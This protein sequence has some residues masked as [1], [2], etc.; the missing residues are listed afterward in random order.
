MVVFSGKKFNHILSEGEIP[1]TLYS[2]S[3]SGW[4]DQDLFFDWFANHFLQHAVSSRPLLL[5]LDGHSSHYTLELVKLAAEND[6]I[7]FCLPPH[8][9]ADSQPL[10]T[11]CFGPLKVY[12]SEACRQFMF[13]NPGC[14]VSKFQ[15]SKLF[16]KAWSKGMTIDNITSGFCSSGIYPFNP[17]AILDKLP[18]ADSS[19]AKKSGGSDSSGTKSGEGDSSST[20]SGD[21]DSSRN[22]QSGED[23]E[24]P[25]PPSGSLPEELPEEPPPSPP[26]SSS[27]PPVF[28]ADKIELFEKRLENEYDIY[29]DTEYVLWLQTFH[30]ESAP[31]LSD[32]IAVAPLQELP[33]SGEYCLTTTQ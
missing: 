20:K 25:L 23:P 28:A 1:G 29:T 9:T 16:S 12:W 22:P 10:D 24:D 19:S 7:I 5:M 4:M 31:S 18:S 30:P 26:P 13:A 27:S 8:T 33:F 6:V 3:D 17:K 32:V 21:G 14:V 2:M 11:S 15:F